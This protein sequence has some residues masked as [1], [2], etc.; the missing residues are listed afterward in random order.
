MAQD[1]SWDQ[2]DRVAVKEVDLRGIANTT[3]TETVVVVGEITLLIRLHVEVT[4]GTNLR[5]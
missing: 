3:E 5:V 1:L 4:V 2:V